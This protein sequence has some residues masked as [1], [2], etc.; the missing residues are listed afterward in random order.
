MRQLLANRLPQ[1][2]EVWLAW[3]FNFGLTAAEHHRA[4]EPEDPRD[5]RE[6]QE[7]DDRGEPAP[8]QRPVRIGL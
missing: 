7:R 4:A 5:R 8:R 6:E 1:W 2:S 3:R